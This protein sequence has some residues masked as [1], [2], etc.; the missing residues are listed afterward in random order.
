MHAVLL[1]VSIAGLKHHDQKPSCGGKG[2]FG[3]HFLSTMF[4]IE[5]SSD[6]NSNMAGTQRQELMQ[7]S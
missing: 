7:R 1:R 4:I 6:R 2:L 5:G 3:L